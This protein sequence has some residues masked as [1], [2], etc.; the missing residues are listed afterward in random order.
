MSLISDPPR[1]AAYPTP[2]DE[3]LL[4][5]ETA[6]RSG[7]WPAAARAWLEAALRHRAD[8]GARLDDATVHLRALAEAGA[9]DAA[10]VLALLLVEHAGDPAAAAVVARAAA[11]RGDA[12]GQ[13]AYGYLLVGGRGVA[14]DEAEGTAW[15]R[16]AA[17]QGDAVAMLN[18]VDA[19]SEAEGDELLARAAALG[20]V[21]AGAL[22]ADR[23]SARDR[24][25]EALRW[26]IWAAERGHTG[27][28]AAA[29][30]W[31]RDGFGTE[32]DPASAVRWYLTLLQHGDGDRLHDAIELVRETQLPAEQV[33]LA[34]A[35]AGRPSAGESLLSVVYGR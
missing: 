9:V 2:L 28:M 33:R 32:P 25:E 35:L 27:A 15:L 31:F 14:K 16:R 22:L 11:G 3:L 8:V 21:P 17:Q 30:D 10:G 34:A 24:D 4:G 29:G 19:A 18:L 7:D 20:L 5:A 1:T 26:L 23:L 6:A 13:R 12:V